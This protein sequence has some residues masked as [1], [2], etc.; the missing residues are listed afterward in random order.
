MDSQS[1]TAF[2]GSGKPE[3]FQSVWTISPPRRAR[4]ALACYQGHST[5]STIFSPQV[6]SA[7]SGGVPPAWLRIAVSVETDLGF[8]EFIPFIFR[9]SRRSAPFDESTA[10]TN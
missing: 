8:P 7:P 3:C 10:L 1:Q 9:L 4:D 2:I 6:V 5:I